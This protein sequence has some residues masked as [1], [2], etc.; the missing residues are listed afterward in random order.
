MSQS[1]QGST[2]A[3]GSGARMQKQNKTKQT[4]PNQNK[5]AHMTSNTH[6]LSHVNEGEGVGTVC[7]SAAAVLWALRLRPRRREQR[8]RGRRRICCQRRWGRWGRC[9]G[10]EVRLLAQD[11]KHGGRLCNC[12]PGPHCT[13]PHKCAAQ[14]LTATGTHSAQ[15]P[16]GK[17][18]KRRILRTHAQ[19][20]KQANKIK[21]QKA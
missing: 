6:A 19:T 14:A 4:K 12:R 2:Q 16:K 9:G 7:R 15:H 20:N 10:W 18:G 1:E 21:V 8:H 11:R 3:D 5:H 17:G 13:V